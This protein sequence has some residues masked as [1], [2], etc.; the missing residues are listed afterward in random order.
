DE[1]QQK[2]AVSSLIDMEPD[3]RNIRFLQALREKRCRA[4]IPL[5]RNFVN[6][7]LRLYICKGEFSLTGF[8]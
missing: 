8:E 6:I 4:T 7:L 3:K 2:R 1:R 5:R